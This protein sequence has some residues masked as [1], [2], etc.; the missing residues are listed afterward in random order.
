MATAPRSA[1]VLKTCSDMQARLYSG[2]IEAR[3]SPGANRRK[4][5]CFVLRASPSV[6][7]RIKNIPG[8][9]SGRHPWAERGRKRLCRCLVGRARFVLFGWGGCRRLLFLSFLQFHPKFLHLLGGQLEVFR[10]RV[11]TPNNFVV[12]IGGAGMAGPAIELGDIVILC[13]LLHGNTEELAVQ[14]IG[15]LVRELRIA[16]QGGID[17]FA[18]FGDGA[19]IVGRPAGT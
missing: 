9:L 5:P 13:G 18:R 8:K 6:S 10:A 4:K 17:E 2:N 19:P 7:V 15:L 1:P 3:S 11:P 14:E 16:A 12:E